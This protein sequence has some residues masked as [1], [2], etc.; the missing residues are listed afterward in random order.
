GKGVDIDP[1]RI[2]QSKERAEKE[3]VK[4]KTIFLNESFF[5]TDFSDATVIFAFLNNDLNRKLRPRFLRLLRPGTRI[6]IHTHDMG[7]WESDSTEIVKCECITTGKFECYRPVR[8]YIVPA[9]VT[10]TWRWKEEN[11]VALTIEQSFQKIKGIL[12]G[13][14]DAKIVSLTIKGDALQMILR[15]DKNGIA[16]ATYS[17]TVRDNL[18]VG[19]IEEKTPYAQIVKNWHAIRDPATWKSI[20]R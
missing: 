8:L 16:H 1:I 12:I 10:G 5:D 15:F 17:G 19:S 13:K 3:G 11:T 7:E 20:D 4:N 14:N 9:N 6:I 18:I 2:V